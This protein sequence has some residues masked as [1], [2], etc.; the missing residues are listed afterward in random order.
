MNILGINDSHLGTACLI[1]DGKLEACISEERLNKI[2][3]WAGFPELSIKKVLEITKTKPEEI[4]LITFGAFQIPFTQELLKALRERKENTI[5]S[6][7]LIKIGTKITPKPLL[8]SDIW[9]KAYSKIRFRGTEDLSKK[10]NKLGFKN[11]KIKLYEHH[12]CHAATAYYLQPELKKSAIITIDAAGDGL[13]STISVGNDKEIKRIEHSNTY[14][15]LGYLYMRVTQLLGMIPSSH[16]YKVMG[17]AAYAPEKLANK[18]YN[19]LKKYLR[20]NPKNSLKLENISKVGPES[21]LNKLQKELPFH[22]FD[23]IAAGIQRLTEELMV[24]L[25]QNTIDHTGIK[26]VVCGGGVFMNVKANGK[27]IENTNV[28]N[29]FVFPSCGDESTAIGAATLGYLEKTD[30]L[31]KPIGPIYLGPEFSEEQIKDSIQKT[32]L[33]EKYE[34]EKIS[35]I[36]KFIAEK[37]SKGKIIG[38]MAGRME[39]GARALGNRTIISDARNPRI[40]D[41]INRAI[42]KRD[43][44][45]PFTPSMLDE[46]EKTYIINPKKI[47]APYMILAFDSTEK[48]REEIPATL[49][50]FDRTCRP[51]IVEKEWNPRYYNILKRFK[52]LTG[53]GGFLNTSFN[54]HGDAMVCSPDDAIKTFVNSDID[55]IALEEFY[56]KRR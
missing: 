6:W 33:K 2:K 53:V 24:K 52:K 37:A 23:A 10:L 51:Q 41:R 38:R 22:R 56:I 49:H 21:L 46:D 7:R 1:K 4:D 13:S 28:E 9:L 47:K 54:L 26:N 29:L 15:S 39:W 14:H 36:D 50:P 44:W 20:I 8:K 3:D 35:D 17:L 32:N 18:S 12:L 11:P 45:M 43:F 31:P 27:I 25:T 48:A 30:K 42:K 5:K 34:I 40:I 19:I 16:E 55:A